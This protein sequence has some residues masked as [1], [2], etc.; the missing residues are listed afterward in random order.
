MSRP[1]LCAAALCGLLAQTAHAGI[2][3][4]WYFGPGFPSDN[5]IVVTFFD[6]GTYYL[7]EDGIA[8]AGGGPG[9][10][11]GTFVFDAVA[12]SL[13]TTTLDDTSGDWGLSHATVTSAV[14]SGDT[15]TLQIDGEPLPFALSRLV[16]PAQAIVGSWY[17][18]PPFPHDNGGVI[19]FL[20][21]GNYFLAEDGIADAG[22]GPGM[23]LGDYTWD[24]AHGI[25]FNGGA[26]AGVPRRDTNGDWGLSHAT[27]TNISVVGDRMTITVLG[28]GDIEFVR[29]PS[30][31]V[32][33]P[34]SVMSLLAGLGILGALFARRRRLG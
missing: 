29:V 18:G 27:V 3:G 7:A 11:R 1:S 21:H 28:E 13:T 26:L 34:G 20:S 24:G 31:P 9:M 14:L 6:D 16:D 12:G 5:G 32:P 25:T 30:A 17:S 15:L 23:E 19:T 22:G 4:G 33:E 8:D 2:A 10:E